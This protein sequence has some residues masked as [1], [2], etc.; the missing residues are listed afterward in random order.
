LSSENLLVVNARI[1]TPKGLFEGYARLSQ[2]EVVEI[3]SRLSP[4]PGEKVMDGKER[5]LLPLSVDLH[6]HGGG[7]CSF[8]S[9]SPEE[10]RQTC[11]A[12]FSNGTGWLLATLPLASPEQWW[13]ALEAIEQAMKEQK[14]PCQEARIMGVYLEGPF[15]N[16]GMAGGMESRATGLW[17]LGR[18]REL[19]ER[20]ANIVRIVTLAPEHTWAKE[21]IHL[22]TESGIKPFLGHSK[23]SFEETQRA[24]DLGAAGFT[25]LFNAMAPYH[26]REPGVLGAALL[27]QLPCEMIAEPAHLHPVSWEMA[28]RL[29]GK[30]GIIPVSDGS[31]LACCQKETTSWGKTGLKRKG[32]ASLTED[33]RLCGT[34]ISLLQGLAILHREGILPIHLGLKMANRNAGRVLGLNPPVHLEEGM[35]GPWAMVDPNPPLPAVEVL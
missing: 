1:S 16:P 19:L 14:S 32:T 10:I 13:M 22:A 34:A 26:H 33:G 7:G 35:Q 8:L 11:G 4:M 9:S 17:S 6:L 24:I 30:E 5:F 21:V 27:S 3:A 25:H 2:G 28:L 12:Q 29:K 23:A 15:L 20:F 18:F 31:P